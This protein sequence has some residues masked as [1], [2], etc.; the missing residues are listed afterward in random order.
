MN[1]TLL[2]DHWRGEGEGEGE[3]GFGYDVTEDEY[4]TSI[5][6]RNCGMRVPTN[7]CIQFWLCSACGGDEPVSSALDWVFLLP[8]LWLFLSIEISPL[9]FFLIIPQC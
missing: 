5:G 1:S 9:Q 7:F 3:G 2:Q 6:A 4:L 8:S